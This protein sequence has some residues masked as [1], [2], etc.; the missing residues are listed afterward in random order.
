[1]LRFVARSFQQG[2]APLVGVQRFID[3]MLATKWP[4]GRLGVEVLRPQIVHHF[5]VPFRLPNVPPAFLTNVPNVE[6]CV[7]VVELVTARGY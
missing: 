6:L 1:M 2:D 4:T 5:P 3:L 7:A